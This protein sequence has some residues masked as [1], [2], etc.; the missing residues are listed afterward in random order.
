MDA[1][2]TNQVSEFV[3]SWGF[4]GADPGDNLAKI[5]PN[6]GEVASEPR[7]LLPGR[8]AQMRENEVQRGM[9]RQHR[10]VGVWL[11]VLRAT[12]TRPRVRDYANSE[13]LAGSE[14]RPRGLVCQVPAMDNRMDLDASSTVIL[15]HILDMFDA[16]A[17]GYN[18][19]RDS[20][21]RNELDFVLR[22]VAE[23]P[24]EG[25]EIPA[26]ASSERTG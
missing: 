5:E 16:V 1:H 15:D 6:G 14:E 18:R 23:P 17:D 13:L 3:A 2:L 22:K 20:D 10:A 11:A 26:A 24:V 12:P 8:A 21:K 7:K 4:G 25:K 19:W 9:S